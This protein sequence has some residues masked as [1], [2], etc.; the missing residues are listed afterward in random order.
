MKKRLFDIALSLAGIIILSPLFL[1]L[2]LLIW[3]GDRGRI[4]FC[5]SRIGLNGRKFTIFKFRTMTE[6]TSINPVS[7]EPGNSK[8]VTPLGRYLRKTKLDELPQL[9][10]VLRGE[11][12]MVGPRPEVV[13]W[14]LV[15]P[16]RWEKVHSV[17]PG[18]TDNAAIMFSKEEQL[19]AGAA[20]PIAVYRDQILP[21]KLDIYEEYVDSHNMGKDLG[22]LFKT[23]FTIIKRKDRT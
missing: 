8:R 2:T 15:Y 7:F 10:N 13:E 22:I 16:E 18:M 17:R 6:S 11:M 9:L 20:D 19:L 12:S 21:R 1:I 3:M 14:V 5:Q 23:L 4:L